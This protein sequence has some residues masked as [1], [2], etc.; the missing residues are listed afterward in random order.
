MLKEVIG[1]ILNDYMFLK[2]L[3]PKNELLKYFLVEGNSFKNNPDTEICEEFTERFK[4]DFPTLE[5]LKK[6]KIKV[7]YDKYSF[8]FSLNALVNYTDCLEGA[9][10]FALMMN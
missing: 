4:G 6:N 10:Q 1:E 2:R 9:I 8:Q 3:S 5:E 7:N